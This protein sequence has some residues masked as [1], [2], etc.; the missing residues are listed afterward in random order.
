M[1]S[2]IDTEPS[3]PAPSDRSIFIRLWPLYIILGGLALAISQGWHQHLSLES[4]SQ[5]A[6][7][8]DQMVRDNLLLVLVAYVAIY[9]V[10]TAFMIPGS[11]LTLGGGFLFP[12][13]FGFVPLIGTAATVVGATL[14]ASILFFAAKT[15]IGAVLREKAGGFLTK[16]EKGFNEDALSYLFALRLIPV[17]PFAVANFAPALLGAKYRD[18]LITTFFGIIPGTLAY[19]WIGSAV[20]STLLEGGEPDIGALAGNF[21]P[22]FIALGVVSLLPVAYKK[23][24]GKKATSL[25]TAG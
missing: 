7:W 2:P 19:T 20:K 15:S 24:F 1:T 23:L 16:M 11:A 3:A 4:L 21:L 12:V 10:A 13:A 9:A 18:Y 6:V 22:A 25:E 17:V 8:L 5:N 14:G